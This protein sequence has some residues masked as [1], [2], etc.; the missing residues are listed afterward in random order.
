MKKKLITLLTLLMLVVTTNIFAN[1]ID[2]SKR[3][4]T[5]F[6]AAFE[7]ATDINWE[8]TGTLSK[9]S[10][11]LNGQSLIAFISDDGE[12]VAVSRNIVSTELPILL[13]VALNKTMP[14]YWISD[15]FEYTS[16]G[17]TRY[18]VTLENADE[19]TI[20]A[21]AGASDWASYKKMAK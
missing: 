1:G 8:K 4:S 3:V 5:A 12:V 16:G 14:R 6:T 7:K 2:I 10:F 18:Y 21:S 17:E 11:H 15:L 20:F 9:A 13:Q 19:K